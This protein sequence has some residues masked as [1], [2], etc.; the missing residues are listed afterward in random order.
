MTMFENFTQRQITTSEAVIN[1]RHAGDGPPVLL[2]H[3]H[4]QTHVMWHRVAPRLAQT[5]TVVCAD[6]RGYGDSSKPPTTPD[7]EP[8]S[9]RAM[10]RDQ[11]EVMQ[12][13]G[14]ERFAV[15][16]HDRGG[17]CA[18]RMALD[19]P[20]R[21]AAL[22][23]LDI[24]PTAEHF[25]RTDMSFAM[26]YWHWFFLAQ[27]YDLPE[28]L[29]SGDPDA[30]Y[31]RRGKHM[32]D[33]AALAEYRRCFTDPATI[34]AMCEDYRAGAGIDMRLD[35]SDQKAGRR[36]ACPVQALWGLKG[37]IDR[38][39]DVCEVWRGWANDVEGQGIECGH[40]LAEEAPEET[41]AA[42]EP[43]LAKALER[44]SL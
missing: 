19:H 20:D 3:G 42:L 27:P 2:L 14:F 7:H 30:F 13:L 41:L 31:L 15:V 36:I 9:K 25:R 37:P 16:G 33:E 5:Y 39:Y 4:P 12:A 21:I 35:E 34:H 11:V 1:L 23:V 17:R 43:F 10:A 38:W 22:S 18:Y 8:Y 44:I 40:Y 32:F 29:I 24:L 28:R 26:G 6:L